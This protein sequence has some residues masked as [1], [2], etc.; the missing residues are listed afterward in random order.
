MRD[1]TSVVAAAFP[2]LVTVALAVV[3]VA[4]AAVAVV[5]HCHSCAALALTTTV[6]VNLAT[7]VA[8]ISHCCCRISLVSP[9]LPRYGPHSCCHS[10]ALDL[11]AV[12]A[13][14]LPPPWPL[15]PSLVPLLL[16]CN[17][18]PCRRCQ[19]RNTPLS[20]TRCPRSSCR[21]RPPCPP[22]P[23]PSCPCPPSPSCPCPLALALAPS[24]PRLAFACVTLAPCCRRQRQPLSPP[25]A[26]TINSSA[27]LTITTT[28]IYWTLFLI[29]G[30]DG[31]HCCQQSG[32]WLQQR[33]H[34]IGAVGSIP[35]PHPSKTAVVDEDRQRRRQRQQSSTKTANS[36]VTD[37]D[38]SR[39]LH[40]P[41]PPLTTTVIDT[42]TANAAVNNVDWRRRLHPTA[43]S[44]KDDRR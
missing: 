43:A 21:C 41:P 11:T 9:C 6:T 36:A 29:E 37:S 8:P 7:A 18:R 26:I 38:L 30:G 2:V 22:L 27:Q 23:L 3:L 5:P 19:R 14:A 31:G 1:T 44:V 13:A 40:P 25:L 28:R 4:A 16:P 42:K 35:P 32:R 17:P 10:V 15:L 33:W 34:L 24:C 39:Q 20:L 12:V